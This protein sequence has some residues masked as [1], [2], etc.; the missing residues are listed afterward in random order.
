MQMMQTQLK[1]ASCK[2]LRGN[3][4]MY[5]ATVCISGCFTD[6]INDNSAAWKG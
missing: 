2:N 6:D 5:D 3:S 1:K 4:L